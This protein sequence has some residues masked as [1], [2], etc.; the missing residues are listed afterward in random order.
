MTN[1]PLNRI[2]DSLTVRGLYRTFSGTDRD[3]KEAA[4]LAQ[5]EIALSLRAIEDMLRD[6]M[7]LK[8]PYR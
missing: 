3:F 6:Y 7:P 5:I 8:D 4:L 1:H 2:R